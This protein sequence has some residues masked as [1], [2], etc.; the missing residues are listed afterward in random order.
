M[1]VAA[2]PLTEPSSD[3]RAGRLE[4][5][6]ITPVRNE[7]QVLPRLAESI[8]AQSAQPKRW[9]I[10]DTGSTDATQ[11]VVR[12]LAARADWIVSTSI[13]E[14]EVARG[15]P[16]VRA[17]SHG[18]SFVPR[19]DIVVKFDADLTADLTF[20]E[21]LLERFADDERLGIA[22]GAIHELEHGE[23]R[24]Q[25]GTDEFVRGACRAY[26]WECLQDVLPLEERIGWDGLDLVKARLSGWSCKQFKD[27]PILHHRTVGEREG[28]QA[29]S[30]YAMGDAMHYMGYRAY[31]TFVAG[32]FNARQDV[33]ALMSIV[34]FA[35]AALRRKPRHADPRVIAYVRAQQ[36][37]RALPQRIAEKLGRA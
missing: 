10:V 33:H 7:E 34:G 4:Y 22:G 24:Q 36:R 16:I 5:A 19:T 6:L 18:L 30:W 26:R 37:M 9:V 13:A 35:A 8:F 28:S 25:F 3:G 17:F 20:F 27:L 2:R 15:G 32:I 12:G 21:S 1:S 23:W 11:E 29:R 14:A 31:Y